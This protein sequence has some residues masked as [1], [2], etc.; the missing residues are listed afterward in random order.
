MRRLQ[1]A[2]IRPRLHRRRLN[3][4]CRAENGSIESLFTQELRKRG[5]ESSGVSSASS[6]AFPTSLP[7]RLGFPMFTHDHYMCRRRAVH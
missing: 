5:L 2:V 4:L 7:R 1:F 6:L 3:V